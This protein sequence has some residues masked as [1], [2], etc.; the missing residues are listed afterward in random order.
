M[1]SRR[2]LQPLAFEPAVLAWLGVSDQASTPFKST[3]RAFLVIPLSYLQQNH[4]FCKFVE[5]LPNEQ[6]KLAGFIGHSLKLMR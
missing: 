4:L 5:K 3:D 6:R 1:E 2:S